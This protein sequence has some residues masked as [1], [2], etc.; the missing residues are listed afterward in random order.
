MDIG[1][2][3]KRQTLPIIKANTENE[4]RSKKKKTE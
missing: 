3:V 2:D 4:S 1:I